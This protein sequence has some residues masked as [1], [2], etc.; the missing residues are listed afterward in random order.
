MILQI[1]PQRRRRTAFTLME[2]M[3][4]VALLVILAGV[5]GFYFMKQLEN[6]KKKTAKAQTKTIAEAAQM[7]YTD[8]QQ[9]PA[10]LQVLTVRD[11]QGGPYIEPSAIITPWQTPYGYDPSGA[12]NQG[13]KPDV[14][15]QAPDGTQIGNW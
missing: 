2:L 11:D 5:G 14:W 10:T 8:H 4:V 7:Y 9:F 6:G 12:H 13:L 15:A 3:V 1:S